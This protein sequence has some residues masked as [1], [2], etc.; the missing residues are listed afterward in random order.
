[1]NK[2]L[3]RIADLIGQGR[4]D[5][6]AQ[7]AAQT[8]AKFPREA[9]PARLHGIALLSRGRVDE[10]IGALEAARARN[11]RSIETLCNLGSARLAQGDGRAAVTVLESALALA[12]THPAV[13]NGLGN[14][15]RATADLIGSRDAYL[16]ATRAAPGYLN[17]WLNLAAAELALH[18]HAEAERVVRAVLSQTA[19]PEACMLLGQA[20]AGQRRLADAEK[21]YA[22]AARLAPD[23]SRFPYQIGLM[24]D[25]QKR[26]GDAAAAH[27]RALA[28]DPQM[29]EALAQLVFIKRQLCDWRD[30]D[31]LSTRLRTAVANG[32]N[33]VTPFGFLAEPATAAEQRQ[34]ASAFAQQIARATGLPEHGSAFAH[35]PRAPGTP[36]RVGFASN[37]F[38]N[39]PTGLLTVAMFE[40]LR[41]RD[42]ELH[43]FATAP[44]DGQSIHQRLKSAASVWHSLAGLSPRAM[45]ERLHASGVEILVD[46]RVWGGGNISEALALRPAPIQVN[47]LAYPGTSG[48]PWIDYVIADRIA[49]PA[50]MRARYS[51]NVAWLPR[52]FQPSDPGRVVGEPP[53]RKECGLP[54]TGAVYVCFNNSYKLNPRSVE[55]MLAIL[56]AVPDSVLWLL[57]GPGNSDQNLRE[58]AKAGGVDPARLEFMSKLGHGEY[59]TRY[60]HADLF[61]DTNPYNAHTTASDAIWAGCPVLTVPG[62]TFAARVAASLNHHLGLP[63]LIVADDAAFVD[64]AVSI[65]RDRS[66]RDALHARVADRRLHSGLFDMHAFA[67]DFL[68]LLE[69]MSARHRSGLAAVP[70]D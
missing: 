40:A 30:L 66:A 43:L 41:E 4:P 26:Y 20:L 56:R 55:R 45:A 22:E 54:E 9:E 70:I 50:E 61:L 21:A 3:E 25:E 67:G 17:A 8:R 15:R 27:A 16:A 29:T 52:C 48:A 64:F 53:S 51:E 7:V 24:A 18:R 46:L 36:L 11:P 1:V 10:A 60:R 44:E 33:Q 42:V 47:W 28:L 37:G 12:P 39:H 31:A 49:L 19:H 65:G 5:L 59:L 6:A 57:A 35:A 13:L 14:A 32:A 63:E 69:R 58:I 62:E 38:G 34:C 2:D 23:D 68:A